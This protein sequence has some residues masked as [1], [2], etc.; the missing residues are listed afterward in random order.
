MYTSQQHILRMFTSPLSNK[1]S[2][3]ATLVVRCPDHLLLC[4]VERAQMLSI[5]G[6]VNLIQGRRV[7]GLR[8]IRASPHVLAYRNIVEQ[9][10]ISLLGAC[11]W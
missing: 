3:K 5:S 1:L 6:S 8:D 11:V 10:K 2:Q 9:I 4:G 7:P